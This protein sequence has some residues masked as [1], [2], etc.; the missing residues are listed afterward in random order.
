MSI[1]GLTIDYGPY[2]WLDNF[3]PTWTPNTTDAENRR[4][5]FENQPTI[6]LWNLAQ[7]GSALMP[8]VENATSLEAGL[9]VYRQRFVEGHTA[10]MQRKLGLDLAT[11]ESA[12]ER[13][14][15]VLDLLLLLPVVQTD[16]TL[17][18]R[19]L[20]DFSC[21]MGEPA[22]EVPAALLAAYYDPSELS[23]DYVGRLHRWLTRYQRAMRGVL[24]ID[25]RA[26]M[27]AVN[28]KYVLRNYLAQEAI[29]KAT[30]GDFSM[31]QTLL[32]VM[33]RPYDEQPEAQHLAAKRPDWARQRAGCSMLSCSS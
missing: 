14:A 19:G 1:L 10:M 22:R 11:H 17:F 27:N 32:E 23:T 31:V 18:F 33:E 4:Y 15:L 9:E 20:S 3:D 6:A 5:R 8:L 7:F 28:P 16:M 13:E 25:R 2:G 12:A 30:V 29:D 26:R 21:E 24:D